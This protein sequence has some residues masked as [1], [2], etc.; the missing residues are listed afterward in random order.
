MRS[1]S[2]ARLWE[3][4]EIILLKINELQNACRYNITM[5][6]LEKALP[7]FKV[8]RELCFFLKEHDLVE[9]EKIGY[10][11]EGKTKISLTTRGHLYLEYHDDTLLKFSRKE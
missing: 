2:R 11:I 9:C 10:D 7:N 8:L 5:G 3:D 6:D 4:C 1:E